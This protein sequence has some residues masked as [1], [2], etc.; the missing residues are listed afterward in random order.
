VAQAFDALDEGGKRVAL[1]ILDQAPCDASAPVYVKAL[2]GK[3]EAQARHAQSRLSRCGAPGGE[4]LARALSQADKTD[5]RLMPL[6]ITQ[7]TVTDPVRA[8][9]AFVPLMDEKTVVRRR[10]LRTALAQAARVPAAAA[11]LRKALSDPAT[12]PV[13]LLDLL[14]A[15]GDQAPRFQPEAGQALARLAAGTPSFRT[16]YLLLGPTAALSAE[17][18]DA[19]GRFR[20]LLVSDPDWHVRAAA[21]GLVK[22]PTRF[23]R[24][25]LGALGDRNV[26]VRQASVLALSSPTA[27]F[28]SAQLSERLHDDDWPLVRAA[29]ADALSRH[30]ASPS[31]DEP[32]TR[33]LGDDSS[34]VRARAIRALGERNV[35]SAASRIRDRLADAEEWPEVRA[36]AARSLG[37]LCDD[38]SAPELGAFAKKLADPMA[39]P[40][41]QLI[42]T[43]AVM[44]LG[45]LA[46]P[47]LATQLAPLTD[48]KSP[49]QARRAAALALAAKDTCKQPR[50]R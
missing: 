27:G 16:R 38:D 6:L 30:P 44:S 47:E 36:E 29:A 19:E 45:R 42:A 1:Q 49:P 35:R 40:D 18:G 25:L 37:V 28:A 26:R 22:E 8:V 11:A 3:V 34:L 17:S 39:S 43:A 9:S 2:M 21:L 24:E 14:R 12:P 13:A 31:I 20:R 23:Q 5:K 15:L 46:Q 41:A 10:L 48:K 33:A 7:L 50:S 4:A 32:L